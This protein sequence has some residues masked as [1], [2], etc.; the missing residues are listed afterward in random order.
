[1][2]AVNPTT[3]LARYALRCNSGANVNGDKERLPDWMDN[4]LNRR[5]YIHCKS[6][7]EPISE[8]LIGPRGETSTVICYVDGESNCPLNPSSHRSVQLSGLAREIPL[9]RGQHLTRPLTTGQSVCRVASRKWDGCITPPSR[10]RDHLR[11][12]GGKTVRVRV[13]RGSRPTSVFWVRQGTRTP[14]SHGW[15]DAP[16]LAH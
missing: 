14:I 12:A 11:R 7:Q 10:L 13:P 15:K 16:R 8:E 5:K 4:Q 2:S 9:C 3:D 6:G 1:M